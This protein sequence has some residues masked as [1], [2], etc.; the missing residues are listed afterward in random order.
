MKKIMLLGLALG[1]AGIGVPAHADEPAAPTSNAMTNPTLTGPLIA[2]PNPAKFDAGPFGPVYVTGVLSGL[3]LL[4]SNNFATDHSANFDISNGQAIAQT[5]SGPLQF[6]A[7]AGI[8]SIPSLGTPYLRA[9]NANST[10]WGPLPAAWA[11]WVVNDDF[12]LQA[13]KLPTLIGAEYTFTF[14]NMNVER[15]LL[16]NQE[17]A[18]SKGVQANLTLGPIAYSV[19]F[20]DGFDSDHFNWVTGS[21]AW[22]IDKANTLAVVAG[23]NFGTTNVN[24]LLTP[25]PQSNSTIVNLI[26]TYNAAPWT[27]T[28]Y[29]QFTSVPSNRSLGF[30]HDATTVGGALLVSYSV[31][32]N[33]SIAGRGEVI[34]SS[35]SVANGAPN[36]LYGPGSTAWSL[37]LTPT[38]QQ[39]IVFARLEGSFVEASSTT[40][41]LAFG[42]SGNEKS[43]GR[44]LLEGGILF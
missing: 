36:L 13:G 31:N 41:G 19:S 29:F 43:Q 34:S 28:P 7:Q 4:E 18:I 5:T 38:Y 11:K 16:W 40:P 39:G 32:D 9:T 1:W 44:L 30:G 22:T 26:Y 15:G 6:Y 37:T 20:T 2:N 42:K 12:N 27:V 35:G 24:T 33:W 21:A 23:G 8:Y 25:A 17:P 10:L 3:G 14:Q